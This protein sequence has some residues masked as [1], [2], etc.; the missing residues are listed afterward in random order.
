MRIGPFEFTLNEGEVSHINTE[1]LSRPDGT[2][3]L[4]EVLC[5]PI[6]KDGAADGAVVSFLDVT[7]RRDV[8]EVIAS[9]RDEAL[10]AA[11]SKA[12]FLANMS[13]EIRTPL[14]GILG[15]LELFAETELDP[16]QA[17]YLRMLKSST[18][19]LHLIVNDILDYS[20]IEAG[21]FQTRSASF[22]LHELLRVIVEPFMAIAGKKKVLLKLDIDDAVPEFV[23]GDPQSIRQVV[24]NLLSNAVKFTDFGSIELNVIKASKI[25]RIRFVL[26]DS[27]NGI[28][29]NEQA[30]LFA[31]FVQAD[32][33]D[34]RSFDGTGLG[35]AISRRLVNL[36]NGTIGFESKEGIGTTFWFELPLPV[37]NEAP[38]SE[39]VTDSPQSLNDTNLN[40]LIVEDNPITMI[41]TTKMLTKLGLAPTVAENGQEAIDCCRRKSF[42]I[43]L[44]DCQMPE[45]DG[46]QAAARIRGMNC[47]KPKII[48]FTA[49]VAEDEE[50]RCGRAGMVAVLRKPF[51]EKDL[52]DSINQQQAALQAR[53]NLD[54]DTNIEEHS[55]TH[56][57]D[58]DTRLGLMSLDENDP[59][60]FLRE[61]LNIYAG[62]AAE[63]ISKMR[64]SIEGEDSEGIRKICHTL[65]GSSGKLG[66]V[67]LAYLFTELETRGQ[68][69]NTNE[70]KG[71]FGSIIKEYK[72][73]T[74][75]IDVFNEEERSK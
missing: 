27:G 50:E 42:D 3:F 65:K 1:E 31:P 38:D 14:T 46:Y 54:L 20:K 28:P 25:D 64:H 62:H 45:M 57:I 18:E 55:I 67:V 12:E 63:S 4:A 34:K 23:F 29:E 33:T 36:M 6:V 2:V 51:T 5:A 56:F 49:S 10:V 60:G 41:V 69:E 61:V 68:F 8:E 70:L 58:E 22:S 71:L 44:M 11:R 43:V 16:E 59:K 47:E 39:D 9:A 32:S 13:H 15:T 30:K 21:K 35:L 48:A 53:K 17:E 19:F 74:K 26:S 66:L 7:D 52:V 37:S 40:V 72:S 75:A 73:L 24:N